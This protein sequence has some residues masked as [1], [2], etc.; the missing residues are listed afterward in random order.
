M[1][2]SYDAPLRSIETAKASP[3]AQCVDVQLRQSGSP[4][5]SLNS[6]HDVVAGRHRTPD[7]GASVKKVALT[8]SVG[9][10]LY[11]GS[12]FDDKLAGVVIE[13]P[14]SRELVLEEACQ[15]GPEIGST[16]SAGAIRTASTGRQDF[17]PVRQRR[18][19]W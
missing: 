10:K 1:S 7:D 16:V 5:T 13:A 15:S 12:P 8:R 9:L 2:G 11:I 4:S 3:P 19:A 17:V 14:P 18:S 6:R